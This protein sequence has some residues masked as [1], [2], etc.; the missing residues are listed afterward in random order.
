MIATIC[1]VL[2]LLAV[3]AGVAV[4]VPWLGLIVFGLELVAVGVA[5]EFRSRSAG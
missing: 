3:A 4:V 5:L 2:G 1:Q